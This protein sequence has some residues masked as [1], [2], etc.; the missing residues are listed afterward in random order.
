MKQCFSIS[1]SFIGDC[2]RSQKNLSQKF[3]SVDG[4][5]DVG[6]FHDCNFSTKRIV[7]TLTC[8]SGA[9]INQI[10]KFFPLGG[11]GG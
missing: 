9:Y 3:I 6:V 11:L 2:W 4:W 7:H 8:P 10:Q 1:Q 5:M